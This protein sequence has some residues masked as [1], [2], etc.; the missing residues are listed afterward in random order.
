MKRVLS[1]IARIEFSASKSQRES[2]QRFVML[3][4]QRFKNVGRIHGKKFAPQLISQ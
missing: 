1:Q 3:T 2:I 4:N